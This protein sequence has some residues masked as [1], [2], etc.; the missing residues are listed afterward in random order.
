MFDLAL[1]IWLEE[2]SK[3]GVYP[4]YVSSKMVFFSCPPL[5]CPPKD[6]HIL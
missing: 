2:E 5:Q 3:R 6:L 1:D 4:C